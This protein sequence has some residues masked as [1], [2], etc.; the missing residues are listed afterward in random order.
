[1]EQLVD[2]LNK[3]KLEIKRE[4]VKLKRIE[5]TLNIWQPVEEIVSKNTY[6]F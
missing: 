5:Y 1:L 4:K 6:A 2:N 3:P